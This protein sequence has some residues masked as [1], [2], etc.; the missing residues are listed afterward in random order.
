MTD[1]FF[2]PEQLE[3]LSSLL[4][5]L[6]ELSAAERETFLTGLAGE[7]AELAPRLRRLLAEM[8]GTPG[9]VFLEQLPP[10][11]ELQRERVLGPYSLLRELGRGGM[12]AV[13]LAQRSDGAYFRQVALKLPHPHLL[14]GR[15]RGRF[16]RERDILAGL[17]H[18]N[19][20]P[21]LDA[22]ITTGG[23]PYLA[24]EWV[25]GE[26]ITAWCAARRASLEARVE[27]ICQ[28]ASAVHYAHGRLVVHRDIKPSNVLVTSEGRVQL[29]DFG[30]AKWLEG[31]TTP[32]NAALT[33]EGES[34]ATPHYAAPEQFFPGGAIT[35]GTDV[36]AMGVLLF[37]LLAGKTP[38]PV[39]QRAG[40]PSREAL[41]EAPLLSRSAEPGHAATL[42]RTPAALVNALKGDLDAIL[43]KA[44]AL[45]PAARYASAEAMADDLRRFLNHQPIAARHIG[46]LALAGKF[47]RRHR[48]GSS[49]V[50]ALLLAI[51]VGAA[52]ILWQAEQKAHEARRA[53]AMRDFLIDIFAGG[54]P[55]VAGSRPRGETTIRE[56]VEHAAAKIDRGL[57][58]D[59]ETRLALLDLVTKT[60]LYLDEP[61]LA[62]KYIRLATTEAAPA[63]PPRHPKRCDAMIF[64]IFIDL[65][66]QDR[67]AATRHLAELDAHLESNGLARS[68]HRADYY[69]AMADLAQ[70]EGDGARRE[71]ALLEAT[72]IYENGYRDESGYPATLGNLA[73]IAAEK[74]QLDL[75]LS[76]FSQGL[77][78]IP[79]RPGAD[80]E[81]A[82]LL[83]GKGRILRRLGRNQEARQD[84][85]AAK[86]LFARTLGE[87][88]PGAQ[89]AQTELDLLAE[90]PAP[91]RG[92]AENG[93]MSP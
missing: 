65:R 8:E 7:D 30:I 41:A 80:L 68:R 83:T 61:E 11:P 1:L 38:P 74:D 36:Y 32:A 87:D 70:L 77:A 75:A 84:L 53:T 54:D 91:L 81:R 66:L 12:G 15:S 40:F 58:E 90:A 14:L 63:L 21:L 43:A 4:D 33:A 86:S 71:E 29:L 52:G 13:F 6:L 9:D 55:R 18:P 20:A 23:Q 62:R 50:A 24:L 26:I 51:L 67:A 76:R 57:T 45:D 37:E 42:G 44:L 22:G 60:Y 56:L 49:L 35:V 10:L 47:L 2:P 27:L 72:R 92:H 88:H 34:L 64:E 28:V 79:S 89:E 48:I 3:R 85:E 82:R 93:R 31:E 16:E 17:K 78:A 39:S 69:L 46:R 19:I 5:R 73:T 59:P 25:E